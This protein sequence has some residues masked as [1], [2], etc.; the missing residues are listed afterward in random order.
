MY[1]Q[2]VDVLSLEI[3]ASKLEDD[4]F[5][6]EQELVDYLDEVVPLE[7]DDDDDDDE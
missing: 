6:Q 4:D 7:E 2:L 5:N 3:L 1:V